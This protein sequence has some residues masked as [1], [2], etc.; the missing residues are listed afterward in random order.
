MGTFKEGHM[1]KNILQLKS[2]LEPLSILQRLMEK[3]GCPWMII[4]GIVASLLG[5]PRFIA[6]VDIVVLIEDKDISGVTI[7]G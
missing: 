5:E 2:L 4:G 7:S 1:T 3:S 6:D